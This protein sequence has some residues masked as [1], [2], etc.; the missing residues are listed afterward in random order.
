MRKDIGSKAAVTKNV[1]LQ[2][3]SIMEIFILWIA[4]C[5]LAGVAANARGRSFWGFFFL[6]FFLSPLV[7]LIA[8]LVV[9]NKSKTTQP[10]DTK[11]CPFCAE[12]IKAEAI[13]CIYCKKD[14]PRAPKPVRL[15]D[16]PFCAQSIPA[17]SAVCKFCDKELPKRKG[18]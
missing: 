4:F 3:E 13:Y 15:I 7:G 18:A 14:L 10:A 5:V 9:Q 6:S 16:C 1:I 2:G 17:D 8:A 12:T 11:K